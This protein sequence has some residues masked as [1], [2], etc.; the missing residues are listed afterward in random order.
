M[1]T[2]TVTPKFVRQLRKL[3]MVQIDQ[4]SDPEGTG[5]TDEVEAAMHAQC[6][7]HALIGLREGVEVVIAQTPTGS[8]EVASADADM[9]SEA[10]AFAEA[11]D[12]CEELFRAVY[13]GELEMAS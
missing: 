3:I 8:V 1:I 9:L 5:V 6:I 2:L 12:N 11:F 13:K 4:L 7:N 10:H